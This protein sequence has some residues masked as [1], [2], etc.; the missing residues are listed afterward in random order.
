MNKLALNIAAVITAI[1]GI[2]YL[3][4]AFQLLSLLTAPMIM[5]FFI[6]AGI[7]QL[8]WVVPTIKQWKIWNY[9]GIVGTSALIITWIL[10]RFQNPITSKP[11]PVN[12]IGILTE[13]LQITFIVLLSV[14][15]IQIRNDSRTKLREV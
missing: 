9:A 11:L 4:L 8:F 10:T 7:L 5:I 1:T 2:L 12:E 3:F 13:V 6:I 14:I 15:S